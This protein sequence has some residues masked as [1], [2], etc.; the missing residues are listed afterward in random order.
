M[1][2]L[3]KLTLISIALLGLVMTGC[4]KDSNEPQNQQ[5][6][7]GRKIKRQVLEFK[8]KLKSTFKTGETMSVDSAV[9][10]MEGL[11]NYDKAN[12]DHNFNNLIFKKDTL[13]LPINNNSMSM[14]QISS[15][16]DAY[17]AFIENEMASLDP[18]YGVDLV[19]ISVLGS[20]L[21]DGTVTMVMTFS[22]GV[23]SSINY[24]LFGVTDYWYW[25]G[26]LG[27]CG[28][29]VGQNIGTDAA[30]KLQL[31]FNN[32]LWVPSASGWNTDVELIMVYPEEYPD[33]NQYSGYMLFFA[34]GSGPDPEEEPCLDYNELN[35]Y[36]SKFD[37]IKNDKAPSGKSFK[38]VDVGK[39]YLTST[40]YW[41]RAHRY[42]LYYAT[43]ITGLPD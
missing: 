15:A 10:Y 29:Y 11:L 9:W 5:K 32:P 42:D 18:T 23:N 22:T 40:E 24:T 43:P 37:Y 6:V 26:N 41:G 3:L 8:E 13:Q 14:I 17:E 27:K 39:D 31:K 28:P 20:M 16:Y 36:L 34:M 33:P 1:K 4:K 35:Y 19:D 30:D 38:C 12:N 21:K 25:G 7:D 2:H